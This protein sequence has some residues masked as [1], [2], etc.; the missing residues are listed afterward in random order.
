YKKLLGVDCS[1]IEEVAS[2][3]VKVAFFNTEAGKIELLQG[4]NAESPISKFVEKRGEGMHHV[5]YL[6][7]DIDAS[8]KSLEKEGYRLLNDT[9]KRGANNKWICF[10]HPKDCNGVLTELCQPMEKGNA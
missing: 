8:M 1:K 3:G 4:M 6:V 2:Q 7:E 9:P 10:L 5:G